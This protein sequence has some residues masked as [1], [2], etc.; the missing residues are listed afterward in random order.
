MSS[1]EMG[2]IQSNSQ[3]VLA[4]FPNEEKAMNFREIENKSGVFPKANA[5]GIRWDWHDYSFCFSTRS[6][7]KPPR[8][9]AN[10]LSQLASTSDPLLA[11]SPYLMAD[12]LLLQK[13]EHDE[14]SWR[15]DLSEEKRQKWFEWMQG[16]SQLTNLCVA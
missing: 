8:T 6:A 10:V 7:P 4:Q 1:L 5:L 15:K 3:S 11:V 16:L 9:L 12:K 2:K 14:P 13:F